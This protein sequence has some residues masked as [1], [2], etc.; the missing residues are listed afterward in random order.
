MSGGRFDYKQYC[1]ND[2][3]DSIEQE[4][5]DAL[6]P[7]PDLVEEVAI[8]VIR[9][10]DPE[11]RSYWNDGRTSAFEDFDEAVEYFK[12]V[13][14]NQE[15]YNIVSEC[16]DKN[17]FRTA[18]FNIGDEYVRVKEWL[19]SHY[20]VDPKTG[21]QYHCPNFTSETLSVLQKTV[22]LLRRA[23]IYANRVDWMLSGDDEQDTM[24]QRLQ[25]DLDKLKEDNKMKTK[26]RNKRFKE[27]KAVFKS[28][29]Q[30]NK[31]QR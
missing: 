12:R 15:H 8:S 18:I 10:N 26:E 25:E 4:I 3:A 9:S 1:I 6:M 5:D 16:T 13:R 27:M 23:A 14:R 2:I 7:R 29:L 24:L 28:E 22:D 21:D 20:P 19:Y 31:K 11:F 30:Q 17:G